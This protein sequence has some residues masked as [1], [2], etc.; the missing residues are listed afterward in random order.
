MSSVVVVGDGICHLLEQK[1][2]QKLSRSF[3]HEAY[4][5][6]S[7]CSL[8]LERYITSQAENCTYRKI[9]KGNIRETKKTYNKGDLPQQERAQVP[10]ERGG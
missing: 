8:G 2:E 7:W 3:P 6:E 5:L 4:S 9:V 1:G 10:A